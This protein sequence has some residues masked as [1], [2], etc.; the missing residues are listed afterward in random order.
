MGAPGTDLTGL[1][2]LR[3][4]AARLEYW[5]WTVILLL[6]SYRASTVMVPLA[7]LILTLL[8][9]AVLVRRLHDVGLSGWWI[10]A[11]ILGQIVVYA[12]ATSV[13]GEAWAQFAAAMALFAAQAVL[14]LVPGQRSEN[15]FGQPPG[16]LSPRTLLG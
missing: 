3:G 15:R 8:G 10:L 12:V 14:G 9:I 4:R 11:A 7:G 16:R 13:W 2:W 1:R 6:A 5:L